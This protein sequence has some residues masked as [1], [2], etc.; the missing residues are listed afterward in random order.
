MFVGIHTHIKIDWLRLGYIN[1]SITTKISI[2]IFFWNRKAMG[3]THAHRGFIT[4]VL[5]YIFVILEVLLQL[6]PY[7]AIVWLG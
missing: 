6:G 7:S 5:E 1:L 3:L 2:Y 4:A